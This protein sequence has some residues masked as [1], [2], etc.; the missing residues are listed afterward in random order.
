MPVNI[1]DR[2]FSLVLLTYCADLTKGFVML[3]RYL[4]IYFIVKLLF[5][6]KIPAACGHTGLSHLLNCIFK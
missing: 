6:A 4:K 2:F 5:L 3:C 1:Y